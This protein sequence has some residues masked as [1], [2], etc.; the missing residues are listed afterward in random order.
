MI[1]NELPTR[2]HRWDWNTGPTPAPELGEGRELKGVRVV[3]L[4][5]LVRMKLTS[6]H[7]KD[8]AHLKDLEEAGL[9]TAEIEASLS[10]ILRD[11]L[12]QVT[13]SE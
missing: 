8:Q 4:E 3:T 12:A 10:P 6:F 11:R 1:W 13:A 2:S 7:L 9:I 5:L